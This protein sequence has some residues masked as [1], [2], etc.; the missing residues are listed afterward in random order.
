MNDYPEYVINKQI[1]ICAIHTFFEKIYEPDF[2]FNGESHN[3]WEVVFVIDGTVGVTA[4]DKVFYLHSG[5]V[6]FH[7]PM[8]FHRIW[9][10][11]GKRPTVCI[12]SFTANSM[13]KMS[14]YVYNLPTDISD[15]IISIYEDA[16]KIFDMS[17]IKIAEIGDDC[18]IQAQILANR[19]ELLL[20]SIIHT[21]DTAKNKITS[22]SI[23][24]YARII[25]TLGKN[26]EKRLT[27]EEI[28]MLCNMSVSSLKKNFNKYSQ[29]GIIKYFNLMKI[30]RAKS[31]LMS[32]LSVK[33]TSTAL[34][35]DDQNYFSTMFKRLTGQSPSNF[36]A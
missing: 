17:F 32:G 19:I 6:I 24:N 14:T 28:A 4:D 8:E 22:Q 21:N 2:Y 29:T 31:L 33:E 11:S 13:P 27:L 35:F 36:K 26:I 23:T 18:K 5:Q 1:D 25:N 15:S 30:N 3:F 10:E 34:G 7:K 20:L 12:I 16:K 9:A